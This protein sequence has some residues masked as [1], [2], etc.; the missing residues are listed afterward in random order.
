MANRLRRLGW[1]LSVILAAEALVCVFYIWL[2]ATLAQGGLGFPPYDQQERTFAE[3][4]WVVL[5]WTAPVL[6]VLIGGSVAAARVGA[7]SDGGLMV[8][9]AL[10]LV[11]VPN[12][13]IA[14][15]AVWSFVEHEPPS[16]D[17]V[18][19][20]GLLILV[21]SLTAAV[22]SLTVRRRYGHLGRGTSGRGRRTVG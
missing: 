17:D 7:R 3:A 9:I 19:L 1:I 11:L 2:V 21:A 4:L 15:D 8:Q 10:L 22:L 20:T 16:A 14:G 13:A 12:A 6:L 5:P 18:I